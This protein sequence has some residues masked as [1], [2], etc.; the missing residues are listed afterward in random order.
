MYLDFDN[1]LARER[2]ARM[3]EEVALNRLGPRSARA[4]RSDGDGVVLRAKIAR[5]ATLVTA[6]FR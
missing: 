4:A 3:R 1:G 5:G 6:L 2:A